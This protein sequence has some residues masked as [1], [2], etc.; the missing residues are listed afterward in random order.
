MVTPW[1]LCSNLLHNWFVRPYRGEGPHV[2]QRTQAETLD[3]GELV[4]EIV[5]QPVDHPGAPSLGSLP[6]EDVPPDRPVQEDQLPVD[7][8]RGPYLGAPDTGF[9]LLEK[10]WI[11]RRWL[12]GCFHPIQ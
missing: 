3:P 5:R 7:G 1:Q 10:L 12:E 6:G 8:Q 2:L 11:A 4:L 9:E